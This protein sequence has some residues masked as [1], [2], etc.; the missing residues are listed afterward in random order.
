MSKPLPTWEKI[1]LLGAWFALLGG[2]TWLVMDNPSITGFVPTETSV[3]VL[4]LE[5]SKTT[6][7]EISTDDPGLLLN[8]KSFRVW[9]TV[10]GSGTVSVWL[11]NTRGSKLLVYSNK[12][13]SGFE[14]ITGMVISN[15]SP[16]TQL[17]DT[18][19]IASANPLESGNLGTATGL[20]EGVCT[21]T[22][23]LPEAFL[24]EKYSLI[25]E[26]EDAAFKLERVSYEI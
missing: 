4:D 9:G 16:A 15:D 7:F 1:T 17:R 22:C 18:L 2:L 24:S 23:V 6:D 25:V 13:K 3:Q 14:S 12:P 5:I 20:V 21:E 10:Y 8:L 26:V 11:D 19:N